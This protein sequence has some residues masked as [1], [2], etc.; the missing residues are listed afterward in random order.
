MMKRSGKILLTALVVS[1]LLPVSVSLA[2]NAKEIAKVEICTDVIRQ[3][4]EIPEHSAP[5]ALLRN[6]QAIAVIPGIIKAGFIAGGRY[7]WG[8]VVKRKDDGSWSYPVFVTLMGGSLGFQAGVQSIDAIMVFK[9]K[10][11][12]EQLARGKFTL[13]GDAAAAAGPV[14]RNMSAA[15]DITLKAEVYTYSRSRGLFAGV[16]LAGSV[17]NVDYGATENFYG[18]T[19]LTA[20]EV[21]QGSRIQN[22]PPVVAHFLQVLSRYTTSK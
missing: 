8:V 14:G 10:Q 21:F 3:F 6:A 20:T 11:S 5:P 16:S 15:T 13:G 4:A 7:G 1:L 17:I 12:I 18:L 9:S 2:D 22:P 19:G